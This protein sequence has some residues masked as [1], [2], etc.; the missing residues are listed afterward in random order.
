[1]I[2]TDPP[3][4]GV[5]TAVWDGRTVQCFLDGGTSPNARTASVVSMLR[6]LLPEAILEDGRGLVFVQ[7]DDVVHSDLRSIAFGRRRGQAPGVVLVP[8]AFF[9]DSGGYRELRKLV[10]ADALPSW[11]DRQ[12]ILFWRGAATTNGWTA[13]GARVGHLAEIPRVALCLRLRDHPSADAGVCAPWGFQFPA[14]KAVAWL[15]AH[16]IFRTAVR[17]VEQADYRYLV[18]IDGVANAWGFFEKLL[19]GGCILKVGSPYEQWFYNRVQPWVHYV[20]V[21]PDL[22]D[23]AERLAW[24]R[25]HPDAAESIGQAGQ[26]FARELTYDDGLL[27][28]REALNRVFIPF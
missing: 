12:D 27:L 24:C 16:G 15:Q 26:A 18:D 13:Q 4:Y 6:E 8:D 19:L 25:N 9:L 3:V 17:P 21:A 11:A 7:Y 20:P 23:L 5:L 2:S 1:M 10:E 28:V 14:E 22:S